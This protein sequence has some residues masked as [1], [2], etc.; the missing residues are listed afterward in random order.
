MPG[1]IIVDIVVHDPVAYEPYKKMAQAAIAQYGGRYIVRGGAVECREGEWKP[2]RVV[3]VEFPTI[4]QARAFY[5]SPEYAP[6]LA[7]RKSVATSNLII[8]EG[9]EEK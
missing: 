4:E 5:D 2:S 6:A 3:V 7:I 8:V 9:W 1:Y